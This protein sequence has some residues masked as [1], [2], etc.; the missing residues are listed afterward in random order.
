MLDS[1]APLVLLLDGA[2]C[3]LASDAPQ[4]ALL[5][6]ALPRLWPAADA[7]CLEGWLQAA[8]ASGEPRDFVCLRPHIRGDQ[9]YRARLRVL[10]AVGGSRQVLLTLRG[11]EARHPLA[12]VAHGEMRP[13]PT[14]PLSFINPSAM[15]DGRQTAERLHFAESATRFA[16]WEFDV[17]RCVLLTGP[18]YNELHGLPADTRELSVAD[19]LAMTHA[20][21]QA[22]MKQAIAGLQRDAGTAVTLSLDARIKLPDGELRW[23]EARI[24]LLPGEAGAAPR[25]FGI[26]LDISARKAIEASLR[27]SRAW[28][29]LAMSSIGMV[30]W[31]RDLRSDSLRSSSNYGRFYGLDGE[32]RE[33]DY[34]E[35][36]SR[37]VP[38]D[39]AVLLDA[40]E[41]TLKHGH[42]YAPKFRITAADGSVRWLASRGRVQHDAAGA[43]E[44]LVGVTWDVSA[45]EQSEQRLLGI[46]ELVPGMVYQFRRAADGSTSHPYCSDGVREIFGVGP[47]EIRHEAGLLMTMLHE[48]DRAAVEASIDASAAELTPWRE[49]YRIRG[50]DGQVHWLLGHANPL[51]ESDGAVVWYGHIM[52]ITARKSAE[53]ALRE[54]EARLTLALSAARMMTWFWDIASDAITTSSREFAPALG[55][56][57]GP[58]TMAQALAAVHPD[59][60]EPVRARIAALIARPPDDVV[61]LENRF[62]FQSGNTRWIETRARSHFDTSTRLL[63]FLC[64]SIDVTA[65]K[66]AEAERERMQRNLQQAQKMEAIGLLTGGIAHDFNNILASILGYSG[67]ALQRFATVMPD[68]LVDYVREVQQ[69]GERGHELVSQMLAFSRGEGTELQAAALPPLVEQ[70]LKMVQPTLP[71]SLSF[72]VDYEDALP[73]VMTNA[74]QLQQIIVNLCINARDAL[75][76]SG[77]IEIRLTRATRCN[78]HCASCHNGFSGEY[79][80]LSVADDGPGIDAALRERI[81]EPFFSTKSG[82]GGSGMGLAMVHGIVHGQGGHITLDSTPGAGARFDIH[83]PLTPAVAGA[84]AMPATPRDAEQGT[85]RARVLVV[86]DERAVGSFIGELL[87]M[88][89]YSVVVESDAMRALELFR[90]TPHQFDLII[91]DQT[92]PRLTGAQ[93]ATAAFALRPGLPVILISGYSAVMDAE[94]AARL[95]LYAFLHKPIRANELL[96][97]VYEALASASPDDE[98]AQ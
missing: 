90:A 36:L 81:F 51:R 22:A 76:G 94:Q 35:M 10:N 4:G 8:L 37:V 95:G 61:I 63:G 93:L 73:T 92:M 75:L 27:D 65:R 69:A 57:D 54:S 30:L 48:D 47:E 85:R 77:S 42:E 40:I 83:F 45:R 60:A 78:A 39:H 49:E 6:A 74:V 2:G 20:D 16:T 87:E 67:L 89:D 9:Q 79:L 72:S 97:V 21:D 52:D 25:V 59:D 13:D 56:V 26:S 38:E 58:L 66:E 18:N 12:A 80:V 98:A 1:H 55:L 41:A 34:R 33:W 5:G 46:A 23:M 82:S 43:P 28:L 96:A 86:D 14:M 11:A 88:S 29:D 84:V 3:L 32:R 71:S 64:V 31:D 50:P 24:A 19:I 62:V 70:A 44:R 91:T 53:M 17:E 7:Q 68:K 15:G